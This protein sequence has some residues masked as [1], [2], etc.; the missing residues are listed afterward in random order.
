LAPACYFACL[1]ADNVSGQDD[2]RQIKEPRVRTLFQVFAAILI[3]GA[4]T[5]PV[6]AQEDTGDSPSLDDTPHLT[7]TGTA[8]AEVVPDIAEISLGVSTEKPRAADAANE[9]AR[10]AHDVISAAKA[11]GVDSQD[12]RTESA[13]LTQVY[14]EVTD[15]NG[16]F[17]GRKPRGFS[18]STVIRL[19]VRA[20][21][22]TGALAQSLIDK[23]ATQLNGISFSIEHPE[24]VT[25]TLLAA[26]VRDAKRQAEIVAGASGLK[27]GRI[28]LIERPDE[29]GPAPFLRSNAKVATMAAPAMP[30]EAGTETL[31]N[32]INVTWAIEP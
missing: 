13:T 24:R 10:I 31:H 29:T 16:H 22:K 23:G 21:D 18:A 20:L 17:T 32:E 25:D 19:R 14:D 2:E 1:L 4:A 15:A 5:A 9:T 27:L 6:H 11:Q 28:L 3:A 12:I 26:A 8:S 30:V 7:M